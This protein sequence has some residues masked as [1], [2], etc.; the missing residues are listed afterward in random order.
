MDLTEVLLNSGPLGLIAGV[1]FYSLR[2]IL[3]STK[4]FHA[5]LLDEIR[6]DRRAN[7]AEM[8]ELRACFNRLDGSLN[9]HATECRMNKGQI[10]Q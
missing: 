7:T 2:E 3:N 1:L 5:S 6:A 10:G 4:T 9:Q 8:K